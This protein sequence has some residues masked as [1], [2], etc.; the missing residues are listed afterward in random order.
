MEILKFAHIGCATLLLFYM[1]VTAAPASPSETDNQSLSESKPDK[2]LIKAVGQPIF[3]NAD[4]LKAL[5]AGS[6]NF[7]KDLNKDPFDRQNQYILKHAPVLR[8]YALNEHN[9]QI[10]DAFEMPHPIFG[11]STFIKLRRLD[12][13]EQ[14][15]FRFEPGEENKVAPFILSATLE[16]RKKAYLGTRYLLRKNPEHPRKK[17]IDINTGKKISGNLDVVWTCADVMVDVRKAAPALLLVDSKNRMV[18]VS[19]E[20]AEDPKFLIETVQVEN[21]VSQYGRENWKLIARGDIKR[22]MTREMVRLSLGNP[23]TTKTIHIFDQ[24]IYE[25]K[26]LYFRNGKLF[27]IR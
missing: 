3:L 20:L 6:E 14:F 5:K 1:Q 22:G 16:N 21:L 15:F 18:M 27:K 23:K 17:F 25:N 13:G 9:F 11:W 10:I 24:W 7:I 26:Y 19:A 4:R 2:Q 12:N 8:Y